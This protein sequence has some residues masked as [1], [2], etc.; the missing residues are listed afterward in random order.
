MAKMKTTKIVGFQSGHDVAY[1]ILENGIPTVHEEMERI[2][3]KKMEYGDGL[4]LFLERNKKYDDINYFTFANVVKSRRELYQK[5]CH[6]KTSIDKMNKILAKNKGEYYEFG[7]HLAHGANAFYTSD[8]NRAL[9]ISI[10]GF[11]LEEGQV[12][13]TLTIDEGIDNKIKRIIIFDSKTVPIGDVYNQSTKWIFGLSVGPP[14]GDQAGTVMAMATLGEAKYTSLFNDFDKNRTELTRIA[15]LSEKEKF[16][17]AASLQEY[18][19]HLFYAH[20]KNFIRSSGHTNLCLSGGVSLNCVMIG[21]IK[22]WFPEI[23]NVFCDPVPYDAGL[24]LGSAR[25]LWHHVLGNPRIKHNVKNI[26]PYLGR[27]YTK[28]DIEKALRKYKTQIKVTDTNDREVL[29]KIADQKIIS[30]FGGGSE[31]GRRALGNRS[32]LADPRNPEMK[33]IIN[34]KVKHRQWFRPLAPSIL[35]ENVADW[36]TEV[37]DSPYMSFA[38]KYKDDMKDKVPAVVHFDGTGRLQTVNKDLSPWYHGFIS[39]W[40]NMTRVPI[41]LNTSFNDSEPIVETPEDA[42]KCFLRTQIDYLYFFDL[43]IMVEKSK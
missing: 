21:K 15:N 11:G 20:I 7:H 25:Y 31:S 6:D 13:T 26:T 16:N 22:K 28:R 9:I 37:Y 19:E 8:F 27:L 12:P 4:K 43:G 33:K 40:D 3:R 41:L 24:S 34:E 14:K 2:N 5:T 23:K 36:F 1:C 39:K 17:V 38:V 32:I 35:E 18:S 42:L 29:E 30:V 10:D